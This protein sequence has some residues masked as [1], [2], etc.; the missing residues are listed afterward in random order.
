MKKIF[1]ACDT[2]SINTVKKIIS[3][4]KSRKLNIGYKFGSKHL[5]NKN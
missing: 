4:T 3:Q 1:F 2:S 5:I